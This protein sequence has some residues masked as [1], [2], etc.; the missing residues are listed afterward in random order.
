MD[1]SPVMHMFQ[2]ASNLDEHLHDKFLLKPRLCPRGFV[3]HDLLLNELIEITLGLVLSN[4][5]K[6]LKLILI[7]VP[8]LQY[9]WMVHRLQHLGFSH[10]CFPFLSRFGVHVDCFDNC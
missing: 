4:D 7:A 10:Y 1:D 3:L 9:E 2:C 5:A 6:L 8:L